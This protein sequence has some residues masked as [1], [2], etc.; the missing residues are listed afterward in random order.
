MG[1]VYADITLRNATDVWNYRRG[2]L[3]EPEIRQTEVRALVDTGA[4]TLVINEAIR[5]QLGLDIEDDDIYYAELADGSKVTYIY[6]EP[7][8]IQWK[9]RKATCEAVVVPSATEVLLGAIPLEAMD[10]IVNPSEQE[11]CGAHG[12]EILLKIK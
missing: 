3:N 2:S 12:D 11:L 7:V 5:Q 9:N 1:L 4:G 10:L 8:Q 6:T